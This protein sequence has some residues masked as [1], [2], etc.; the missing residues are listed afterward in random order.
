M[1]A[2]RKAAHRRKPPAAILEPQ[3]QE[4]PIQTMEP[5]THTRQPDPR[6]FVAEDTPFPKH[7][8]KISRVIQPCPKCRRVRLDTLAQA[9]VCTSSRSDVAWF[10]CKACGHRWGLPVK[11]K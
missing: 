6:C 1:T 3:H 2:H 5:E 7:V 10:R 4:P 11:K 8:L 9:T